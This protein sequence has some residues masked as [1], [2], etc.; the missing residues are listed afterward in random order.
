MTRGWAL[1][2]LAAAAVGATIASA[3]AFGAAPD[4]VSSCAAPAGL[5]AIGAAL[6][7]S[8]ARIEEGRPLTIVAIGSSSTRGAGAT[9]PAMSYP[10]RLAVE[11]ARRL[12]A[13]PVTVVNHGIG[14]QDVPE[15]L[16]RL[17]TDVLAANPDL[18]IWQVGTNAVL[19]RDDLV[20]DR[21]LIGQGVALLKA[22][23]IDV[24]L[25]DLQYAPRVLARRAW[26]EM[27]QLISEIADR[28][29][30]GL[31]R[32]F[33]IMH[34]WERTDRLAPAAMIGPDGLHMTDASYFCLAQRLAAALTA[35]WAAAEKLAKSRPRA[36]A[37]VAR[38]GR[39][40]PPP[41]TAPREGAAR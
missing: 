41:A 15:E 5:A 17:G 39:G 19:R 3:A 26:P 1:R 37:A 24:V 21:Q 12:P 2:R 33:E 10:S 20:A 31:F 13:I 11:L 29:R 7:R 40:A 30:I 9:S 38:L 18:V 25:M 4:T 6:D 16:K 23:G 34:D 28:E 36:T 22:H 8:T 27:E 32:R 35:N 14:G